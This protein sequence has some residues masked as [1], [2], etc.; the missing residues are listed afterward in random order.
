MKIRPG[1]DGVG[2]SSFQADAVPGPAPWPG[3]PWRRSGFPG[4]IARQP[5]LTPLRIGVIVASSS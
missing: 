5:Y 1:T 3:C 2:I 4:S